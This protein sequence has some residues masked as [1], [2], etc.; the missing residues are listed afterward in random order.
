LAILPGALPANEVVYSQLP[1]WYHSVSRRLATVLVPFE[2]D[3]VTVHSIGEALQ[4]ANISRA[5]Y[6]RWVR[7]GRVSD[8][9]YRDRNG[10]R[11]FTAEEVDRLSR[12]ANRLVDSSEQLRMPLELSGR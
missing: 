4:R 8:A 7:Q 11:V 10:R 3:G 5:T 9:Q 2:I 6:F 1:Q 12:V